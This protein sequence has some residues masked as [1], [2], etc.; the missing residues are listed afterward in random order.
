MEEET[1]EQLIREV[2]ALRQRI[3]QLE[4]ADTARQHL[5]T[6]LHPGQKLVVRTLPRDIINEFNNV[7]T[8]ILGYTELALSDVPQSS[9]AWGFLQ[10]VHTAGKRARDLVQLLFISGQQTEHERNPS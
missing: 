1:K 7:L 6:P 4:A 5:E 3:A 9:M 8:V 10:H 2:A